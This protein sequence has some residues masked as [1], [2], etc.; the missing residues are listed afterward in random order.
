MVALLLQ[1][2][3][4]VF[5]MRIIIKVARREYIKSV[6]AFAPR[7]APTEALNDRQNVAKKSVFFVIDFLN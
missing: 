6:F 3:L 4:K 2:R 5:L 1:R 7:R